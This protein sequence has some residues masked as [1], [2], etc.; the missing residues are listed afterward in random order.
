MLPEEAALRGKPEA[1]RKAV[2]L[3]GL[4]HE[5]SRRLSL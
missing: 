4:H 3:V 2:S 1:L 5:R